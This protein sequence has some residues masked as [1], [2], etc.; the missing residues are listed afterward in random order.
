MD[1]VPLRLGEKQDHVDG[2][3][4][5]ARFLIYLG[6]M[7][8]ILLKLGI[9]GKFEFNYRFISAA[10]GYFVI[11]MAAP[12][13]DF[14]TNIGWGRIPCKSVEDMRVAFAF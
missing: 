14:A 13:V 12:V 6:L 11:R 2:F 9:A 8:K 7:L 4:G 1:T 10:T 5:I 3:F